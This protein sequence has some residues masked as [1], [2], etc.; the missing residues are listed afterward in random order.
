MSATISD[1]GRY[2]YDLTRVVTSNPVG[3]V[4]FIGINPSTADA[5]SNDHSVRKMIGF[6]SR[7]GYG[8][9]RLG[10]VFG[11]RATDVRELARVDNPV[12]PANDIY[13]R[14][15][16]AQASLVVPCWGNAGK[17]PPRLRGRIATVSAM[18][19]GLDV[20]TPVQCL[21]RTKSGDPKHPLTLGYD[22]RLEDW[23]P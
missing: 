18:L 19:R 2:R 22:T 3:V 20:F 9:F 13:L 12:G 14:E 11:Y 6:T 10:N 17:L 23:S 1:C 8:V 21:G 16:L 4:V 5:Q 7:W 15:M